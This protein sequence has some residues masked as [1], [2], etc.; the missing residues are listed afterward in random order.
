[1]EPEYLEIL[2]KIHAWTPP[3]GFKRDYCRF[4]DDELHG[5][6]VGLRCGDVSVRLDVVWET[7]GQLAE[8]L[9]RFDDALDDLDCRARAERTLLVAANDFRPDFSGN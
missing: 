9:A 6:L 1:M 5:L 7:D 4:L 3:E 8:A 2:R